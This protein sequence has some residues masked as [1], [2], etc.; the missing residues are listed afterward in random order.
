MISLGTVLFCKTMVC[1]EKR[2]TFAVV[3]AGLTLVCVKH[4][5][6]IPSV[7]KGGFIMTSPLDA[8][9]GPDSRPM[10]SS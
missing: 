1:L 4:M 6:F 2:R 10:I 3:F 9:A 5:E 7:M 8:K